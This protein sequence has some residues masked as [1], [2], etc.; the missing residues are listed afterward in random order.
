VHRRSRESEPA[1]AMHC[2]LLGILRSYLHGDRAGSLFLVPKVPDRWLNDESSPRLDY[3]GQL[4]QDEVQHGQDLWPYCSIMCLSRL[5]GMAIAESGFAAVLSAETQGD[6]RYSTQPPAI[7]STQGCPRGR[8]H[9]PSQC[10]I[11][12]TG[13]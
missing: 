3:L 13:G 4:Y 6:Q 7:V 1:F 11:A 9:F 2:C 5:V 8:T 12:S 10:R